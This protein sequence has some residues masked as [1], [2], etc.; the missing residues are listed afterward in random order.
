MQ[1]PSVLLAAA[2]VADSV[3]DN[4]MA[5]SVTERL[6]SGRLAQMTPLYWLLLVAASV[7]LIALVVYFYIR[8]CVELAVICLWLTPS[9]PLRVR[10]ICTLPILVAGAVVLL[11]WSANFTDLWTQ[12]RTDT[13][14]A[15][16]QNGN[17]QSGTE[18][19]PPVREV[20]WREVLQI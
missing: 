18:Q 17:G 7:V 6:E 2:G 9:L 16:G 3:A 15:N 20:N 4:V 12:T 8:D 5:G 1:V 19:N 13:T 11:V 14:S 10:A